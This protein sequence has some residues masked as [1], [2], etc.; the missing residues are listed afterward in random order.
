MLSDLQ[1]SFLSHRDQRSEREH[2]PEPLAG[3][4]SR[5]TCNLIHTPARSHE[6]RLSLINVIVSATEGIITGAEDVS[7][8]VAE[9]NGNLIL[10]WLRRG[11]AEH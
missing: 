3:A 4:P 6:R 10:L 8:L 2:G 11:P 1:V 9:C 7:I 5:P